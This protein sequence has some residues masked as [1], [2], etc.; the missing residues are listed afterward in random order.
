MKKIIIF[1]AM[2]LSGCAYNLSPQGEKLLSSLDYSAAAAIINESFESRGD[3]L[4]VCTFYRYAANDPLTRAMYKGITGSIVNYDFIEMYNCKQKYVNAM[5]CQQR[6]RNYKLDLSEIETMF[7]VKTGVP[8][9]CGKGNEHEVLRVFRKGMGH[10]FEVC[11]ETNQLDR[12]L[13]AFKYFSPEINIK[14][15][16]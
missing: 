9:T 8:I 12:T 2:F 7:I 5:V 16:Y 1:A 13:A 14:L 15:A 11:V 3:C 4:G 10:R 6:I